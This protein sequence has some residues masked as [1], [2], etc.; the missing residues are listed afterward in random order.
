MVLQLVASLAQ[1]F[2]IV[3][4]GIAAV[5]VLVVDEHRIIAATSA[6]RCVV[7]LSYL[8][9]VLRR[10]AALPC[11]VVRTGL[12]VAFSDIGPAS[13]FP[14]GLEFMLSSTRFASLAVRS[15]W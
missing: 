13:A 1:S 10:S 8:L 6:D 2:K 14:F 5:A 3:R 4:V 9:V 7:L 15:C 11:V 12:V